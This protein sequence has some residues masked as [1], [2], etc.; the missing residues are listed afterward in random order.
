MLR[1]GKVLL[2]LSY[3]YPLLP[4][5]RTYELTKVKGEDLLFFA[6]TANKFCVDYYYYY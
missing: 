4:P 1:C 3:S 5:I 6:A 2:P